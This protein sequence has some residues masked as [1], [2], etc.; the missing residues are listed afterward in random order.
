[1]RFS[2]IEAL[3]VSF[4]HSAWQKPY[5]CQFGIKKAFSFGAVG[6]GARGILEQ[7]VGSVA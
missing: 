4:F 3:I 1:M 2:A 5:H 7:T 6:K